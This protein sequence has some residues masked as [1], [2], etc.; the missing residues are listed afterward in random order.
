MPRTRKP[1]SVKEELKTKK[2]QQVNED[3]NRRLP[4]E[5]D[6]EEN[7]FD[8]DMEMDGGSEDELDVGVGDDPFDDADM[9][10]ADMEMGDDVDGSTDEVEDAAIDLMK[11]AIAAIE[12][13]EISADDD[14]DMDMDSDMDMEMGD[15]DGLPPVDMDNEGDV[16]VFDGEDDEEEFDRDQFKLSREELELGEAFSTLFE[17]ETLT[18]EFK[19]NAKT[20][21]EEAIVKKANEKIES[22]L[23]SL[24]ESYAN[25]NEAEVMKLV[26]SIEEYLDATVNEWFEANSKELE[27]TMK[28]QVAEETVNKIRGV[29]EE[30]Y[31][32]LP[33]VEFHRY[34]SEK[35]RSENYK[36][37]YSKTLLEV[38][39]LKTEIKN[40]KKESLLENL[41]SDLSEMSREKFRTLVEDVSYINEDDYTKK[42]KKIKNMYL[43]ETTKKPSAMED[44]VL[45]KEETANNAPLTEMEIY[46][47]ALKNLQQ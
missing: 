18:E 23:T 42:I 43:T 30:S 41:T 14:M 33:E 7:R 20:L 32:T 21:F 29:L 6:D 10:D 5:E 4:D 37:A 19:T 13:G 40:M 16:D 36:K 9:S 45:L 46:S 47:R 35:T 24:E 8:N 34:E 3:L 26:E 39:N 28:V 22:A 27:S 11:R 12:S 44:S 2:T 31:I 17:G 38:N 1:T 25:K 15:D